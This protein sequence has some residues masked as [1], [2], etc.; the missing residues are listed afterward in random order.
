MARYYNRR[1]DG[2]IGQRHWRARLSDGDV[3]LVRTLH[4]EHGLGYTALSRKFDQPRA[5]IRDICKYWTR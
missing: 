5:T 2:R 4:Q 1:T 3:Q